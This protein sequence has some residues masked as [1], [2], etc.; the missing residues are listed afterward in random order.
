MAAE[1]RVSPG[2][3][4]GGSEEAERLFIYG[5]MDQLGPLPA[6][7]EDWEPPSEVKEGEVVESHV[8]VASPPSEAA[9]MP[10]AAAAENEVKSAVVSVPGAE[11]KRGFTVTVSLKAFQA[12]GEEKRMES[13][14]ELLRNVAKEVCAMGV[15][16][17]VIGGHEGKKCGYR[18]AHMYFQLK[19]PRTL[20]SV[21]EHL[22]PHHC[23][24]VRGTPQEMRA[25]V[26]KDGHVLV[27]QGKIPSSHVAGGGAGAVLEL[28]QQEAAEVLEEMQSGV[29][30]R[31]IAERHPLLVLEH[32]SGL[33]EMRRLV[34]K[35]AVQYVPH[36]LYVWQQQLVEKLR[37]PASDR[38]VYVYVDLIGGCGKTWMCKYMISE[39]GAQYF[40]AG[41]Y[42]DMAHQLDV[43]RV[44]PDGLCPIVLIDITRAQQDYESGVFKFVECVKNGM[45]PSPKYNSVMKLI[46]GNVHVVVMM[47]HEPTRTL[48]SWDRWDITHLDP[49]I[50]AVVPGPVAQP[51]PLDV[52]EEEGGHRVKRRR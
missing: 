46:G 24:I 9:A 35:L 47:N 11:R 50:D 41:K 27:E 44:P 4:N 48:L 36:D 25:Y 1:D 40:G 15:S 20:R 45:V 8:E 19:H 34:G 29:S 51:V 30:E 21:V 33:H 18:H 26:A 32:H 37:R 42:E 12:L 2:G 10:A 49:S 16:Y 28:K 23:E 7:I 52:A 14:T 13:E 38:I 5:G 17:M 39:M 31:V 3:P 22:R 6:T 43:S